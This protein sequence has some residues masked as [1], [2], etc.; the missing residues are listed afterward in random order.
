MIYLD[1]AAT[2]HPKP[3]SVVKAV[4]DAL[5]KYG[6]NPG[7]GTNSMALQA[8]RKVFQ[9]R[10]KIADFF[11]IDDSSRIIFTS[12]ATE[13]LNLAIKGMGI[14]T[15]EVI[16][17]P[18]EHNSVIRP[19]A[20][21]KRQG[22]EVK[23]VKASER[24][25]IDP[26]DVKKIIT[27]KTRLAVFTHS[28]NV[29]GTIVPINEIGKICREYGVVFLVDAAQSAGHIPIDV[30]SSSIDLLAASGHKGL[31]GM[32]GTGFLYISPD[33]S[34]IPLKE[35]GTGSFS[36]SENQPDE[37]PDKFE[38]GTLNTPGI[39]SL[40]AGIDYIKKKGGIEAIAEKEKNLINKLI[41]GIKDIDRIELYGLIGKENRLGVLSLNI[42]NRDPMK[43]SEILDKKFGI[44]TRA[45]IHCAPDA[46]RLAGTFPNGTVRLS[47]GIF[48]SEKDIDKTIKVLHI[49]ARKSVFF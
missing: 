6:G 35:G 39:V 41:D 36:E 33:V 40:G 20:L 48:N 21:L 29:L 15:G 4:N 2:S 13:A 42:K 18:M 12:N 11:G 5:L 34:L 37:L 22:V 26:D 24:G 49:L 9:V 30:K 44:I 10:E 45:G 32:Q 3:P 23:K 19:L 31:F 17:S 16:T 47:P 1:N 14:E 25:E 27:K 46:H 43:V 38:S 28:S 7:R 8:Y